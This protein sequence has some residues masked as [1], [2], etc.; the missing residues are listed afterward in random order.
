MNLD[1]ITL[2][3][4]ESAIGYK[5]LLESACRCG[6]KITNIWDGK[7]WRGLAAK[8]RLIKRY[9]EDR[10]SG[11]ELILFVDGVDVVFNHRPRSLVDLYVE[12]GFKI[13]FSAEKNCYPRADWKDR[14]STALGDFRFL[15]SGCI[16]GPASDL[17][18]MLNEI[19]AHEIL[20]DYRRHDGEWQS[21]IDQEFFSEYYLNHQDIVGLDSS[22]R[23]CLSLFPDTPITLER[24][25]VKSLECQTFPA[26]LHG[27]GPSKAVLESVWKWLQL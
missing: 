16:M 14:F 27:N 12:Q 3:T 1:V 13:L 17:L 11:E 18:E 25:Q 15:N 4:N 10:P 9:L 2:A 19:K 20:D 21:F 6:I 7:P 22:C 23:I 8:P 5:K 26:L 24:N